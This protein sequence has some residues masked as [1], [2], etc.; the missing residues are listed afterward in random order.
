MKDIYEEMMAVSRNIAASFPKP[1]FYVCCK[2]SLNLSRSLF[3][4]DLQVMKCRTL[5]LNELKE[6]LG[7]GM[8]HARKVALEARALAYGEFAEL[9]DEKKR[10]IS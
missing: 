8:D 10:E 6:D 9:K 3:N 4:E 7:H 5:M 2:E 1:S